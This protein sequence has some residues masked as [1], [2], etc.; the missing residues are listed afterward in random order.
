[1][2]ILA[3]IGPDGRGLSAAHLAGRVAATAS[4]DVV[5][6]CVVP[7][8]WG[9]R[10]IAHGT[11]AEW[12]QYLE[13]LAVQALRDAVAVVPA[14]IESRTVIRVGRSVPRSILSIAQEVEA[15]GI[16]LGSSDDAHRGQV[17]FGAIA[18]RLVH[19][20]PL[21]IGVAPRSFWSDAGDRVERLVLGLDAEP[22]DE[23]AVEGALALAR[24]LGASIALVT[25]GVRRLPALPFG[26]GRRADAEV[27]AVWREDVER[28][29]AEAAERIAAAGVEVGEQVVAVADSWRRVAERF[30]W[31]EGDLLVL[32]SSH[33]GPVERVFLGST[34]ARIAGHV[35]V[36]VVAL[37]RR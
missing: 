31:E 16:V 1:M 24:W 18:N 29:H 10:T 23:G 5:L 8:A 27:F 13:G 14:E 2:T 34:A 33:E 32:G 37:P 25:F 11:D 28:V 9:G 6:C 3:A 35:P 12:R 21:P 17:A 7:D 15:R 26:G 36:G 22:S 4:D 30:R 19:S 20:S